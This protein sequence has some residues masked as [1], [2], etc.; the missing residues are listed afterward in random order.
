MIPL[1]YSAQPE[2]SPLAVRDATPAI[3]ALNAL[4]RGEMSAIETYNQ[5]LA[6][7]GPEVPSEL[8]SG[9]RSHAER[10]GKL[11]NQITLLGGEPSTGSGVWGAF[12]KLVEGGAARLG[13]RSALRALAE[14]ENHGQTL[15]R[16]QR[17]L[18]DTGSLRLIDEELMLEQSRT[19]ALIHQLCAVHP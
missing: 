10:A 18:V 4:L 3:N 5:V 19:H 16:S 2:E 13:Q 6:H 11:R 14:G 9:L 12:A 8:R 7:C 15:Y 17:D 1:S